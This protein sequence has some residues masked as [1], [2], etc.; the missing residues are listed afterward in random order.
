MSITH[1]GTEDLDE[2]GS[3][4]S[5]PFSDMRRVSER[6]GS[7]TYILGFPAFAHAL[8]SL[9]GAWQQ[10]K[11]CGSHVEQPLQEGEVCSD[12]SKLKLAH[13]LAKVAHGTADATDGRL[14]S[15]ML[16]NIGPSTA[17]IALSY[18]PTSGSVLLNTCFNDGRSPITAQIEPS[19]EGLTA[20]QIQ[21]SLAATLRQAA[22]LP[23]LHPI[24]QLVS[25]AD[26][27]A[28]SIPASEGFIERRDGCRSYTQYGTRVFTF[29]LQRLM[30]VHRLETVTLEASGTGHEEGV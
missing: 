14:T 24:L 3:A 13:Q 7:C 12:C 28:P 21:Q 29:M 9:F 5:S 6:Y 17:T 16:A 10:T 2:A 15:F 20:S 19:R 23:D 27:E 26:P 8:H 22:E 1:T 11:Q 25:Y 18:H 30:D 4:P